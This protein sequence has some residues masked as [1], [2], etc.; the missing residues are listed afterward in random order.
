MVRS[1][2]SSRIWFEWDTRKDRINEAKHGVSFTRAQEAFFDA[3]RV[4]AKNTKHSTRQDQQ[5]FC[6]G[7]VRNR[8][9]TVRFTMRDGKTRI[10][11]TGFWRE[12]KE[13]YDQRD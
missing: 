8:V 11:G 1:M 12:G 9:L 6:F 10:F 2:V 13:Q 3:N 5:F 4:I 7:K